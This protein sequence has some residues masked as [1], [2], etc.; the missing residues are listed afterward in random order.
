MAP[1]VS[2]RKVSKRF[3]RTQVLSEVDF[4]VPASASFALAGENGAGKTTLIK[5]MLDFCHHEGGSISVHGLPS[6][7]PR[8]R[9]RLAFLP[10]RFTP[11]WFLTGRE[12]LQAMLRLGDS[13]WIEDRARL[14]VADLG[15]EPVALEQ[16]VRN[17]SKGMNQ[18]L[19][20]AACLLSGRDLLVLDEPMTGLDPSARHRVK[21]LLRRLRDEGRTLLLT[22]HSLADIEEICDHMAVLHRGELAFTGAPAELCRLHEEASLESAFLK[23]IGEGSHA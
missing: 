12:F 19:G 11:P 5:C 14:M 23:C 8:A 9:S 18:K 17:Y 21:G 15:L 10:E 1:V 13:P 3:G 2:F 16:P 20:L 7:D 22:S 6:A 4:D